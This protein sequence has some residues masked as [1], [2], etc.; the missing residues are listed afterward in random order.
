MNIFEKMYFMLFN[1]ITDALNNIQNQNYGT[2]QEILI[3][4]LQKAEEYYISGDD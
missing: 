2:A 1:A 3:K 4:A